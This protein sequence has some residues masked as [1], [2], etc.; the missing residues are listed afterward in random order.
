MKGVLERSGVSASTSISR[1]FLFGV[2][3]PFHVQVR[4]GDIPIP[5]AHFGGFHP[6]PLSST[7]RGSSNRAKSEA[8]FAI[9]D[10]GLRIGD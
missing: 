8:G 4:A 6:L 10:W 3:S 5:V 7:M 1:R 9:S 2:F